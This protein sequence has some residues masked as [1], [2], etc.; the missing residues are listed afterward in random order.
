MTSPI[1]AAGGAP[2]PTDYA[3]LSMD[4]QFTGLSTQRSPLRDADVPYLERKFYS[5][6]RFDSIL[7]GINREITADLTDKRRPGSAVYNS[8]TF[9]AAFSMYSNKWIQDGQEIVRVLLD[10]K[11]GTIYDATAGQKSTLYTKPVSSG[12]AR[13]LTVGTTL[14]LTDGEDTAQIFRSSTEWAATTA[15]APG[16]LIVAPTTPPTIQMA[17]GGITFTII[18]SASDG[19]TITLYCDP[20]TIPTQFANLQAASVTFAGLTLAGVLNGTTHQVTIL[21]TTL[22]V[23]TVFVATGAYDE[24]SDTGTGTTGNGT[25]GSS[26]PSFSTTQFQITADAGQQWK[27]YGPTT[28]KWGV[29]APTTSPT[30]VPINSRWW[31]PNTFFFPLYVVL[32]SNQN[33]EV[34]T[35]SVGGSGIYKTGRTYPKW[36]ADNANARGQTVDGSIIWQSFGSIGQW[37]ASTIFGVLPTQVACILDSNNNLQIV[38]AGSG[39][40]SGVTQPT[41]ATGYGS[42]TTDGTLT[43]TNVGAAVI[44]STESVQYSYSVHSIDGSVSNAA[45]VAIIQGPAI[46][47][48][49][50]LSNTALQYFNVDGLFT[51]DTQLD[52]IWIWR[53]PQGESTL[54]LE[55][56]IPIDAFYS[57]GNFMYRE[58]GI[59]DVSTGGGSLNA[60]VSAPI[61]DK[62]DPPPAGLTALTYHVGRIWGILDNV[63]RYS[64]GPDTVTGNGNT[65]WPPSN[66]IPLLGMPIFLF[67]TT[68]SSGPG[69]LAMTTSGGQMILGDG[70]TSSIFTPISYESAISVSGYNAIGLLGTTIYFMESNG[71]VSSFDPANGYLEVGFPIGDQFNNVTTGAPDGPTG[72]LYNPA[73]AY[74]TWNLQSSGESAMYV[75]DGAVGWFRFSPI[76]PPE[77]GSLWSTRAVILGGTSAVQSIETEPGVFN[78]LIAP[79][80]SGPLLMRDTT[81]T[82]WEDDVAGTPTPYPAWDVKGVITL[83]ET[84]QVAEIAHV[85]L[86]SMPEGARPVASLLL[87]EL[88]ATVDA[89]WAPLEITSNDPPILQPSETLYSDRY[90]AEQNGVCPKSDLVSLKVDYGAQAFGD[91][92]LKFGIYGRKYE[93]R[94][95]K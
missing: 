72:Q 80:S 17:L 45:P 75:A 11:D 64:G 93:E 61:A 91:E 8:N 71:K 48:Y 92:L 76:A 18:A 41:W 33:I 78:L 24:A 86:K 1:T 62:A 29:T 70:T 37:S 83:C 12:Q 63:L 5:A 88:E 54:I 46:G 30:L 34:I 49:I 90:S 7:D 9:P 50:A 68:V 55:D 67:P 16:T 35:G 51:P 14:F 26:A 42:T 77:T 84:G 43:W 19:G 87:G 32:D 60:L 65:A 39:G 40:T 74:V 66:S 15:F 27:C 4:T 44:I 36:T 38:T 52:Q 95:Q 57:S 22:G 47:P 56:Q 2:E 28:L 13:F 20:Q 21:S 82:V 6:S 79:A 25:T 53:T 69:L 23:L 94:T 58:L 31:Q 89:P 59:P 81:K 3:A 10:G 73:T 85:A